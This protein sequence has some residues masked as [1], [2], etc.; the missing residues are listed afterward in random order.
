MTKDEI[1]N[2][3]TQQLKRTQTAY[4]IGKNIALR[5]KAYF[6]AKNKWKKTIIVMVILG[7][8]SLG[9]WQGALFYFAIGAILFFIKEKGVRKAAEE[10]QQTKQQL[11]ECKSQAEYQAGLDGFPQKFYDYALI[12]RLFNLVHEGRALTLQEAY[13]ILEMQLQNEYQN[14]LAEKNLAAVQAA[15]KNARIA[16]VSSTVSAFN[17]FRK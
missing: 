6:E 17:S 1:L 14:G 11:I 9:Q 10:L 13:N 16:A 2:Y 4:V 12:S 3:L 8:F 5:E 15:E 7:I